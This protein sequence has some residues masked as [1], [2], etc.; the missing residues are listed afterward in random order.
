M[1][2]RQL[3]LGFENHPGLKPAGR[4]RGRSGRANWWFDRMR[5]I[6][7]EARDWPPARPPTNNS[8]LA[9]VEADADSQVRPT[10][11]RVEPP[12]PPETEAANSQT[13]REVLRWR[14]SRT[15]RLIWE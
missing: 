6:V 2:S 3:E 7:N 9:S 13:N 8:G 12:T 14:F 11:L 5:G 1:V 10:A 4:R 15:R